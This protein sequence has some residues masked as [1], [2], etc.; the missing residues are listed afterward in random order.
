MVRVNNQKTIRSLSFHFIKVNRSRNIITIIAIMLTSVLFTSVFAASFSVIKSTMESEIRKSM[1]R[2]HICIENMTKEQYEMVKGD[3][4]F[5]KQGLSVFLALA[6]NEELRKLQTE[7]RY[8]DVN[9]AYSYICTPTTGSMPEKENEIATSTLVLDAFH[10]PHQVGQHIQLEFTMNQKIFIKDFIVTGFWEGDS[11]AM[12]QMVWVSQEYCNKVVT[13]ATQKD[14][15]DGNYAGGYDLSV[16]LSN[17]YNLEQEAEQLSNKYDL[18]NSNVKISANPAY[19]IFGVDG[20]PVA[21]IALILLVI[22]LAGYLII[23]NVF[24]ISVNMDIRAYGLLKN[25]GTTGKQLKTIV[26]QQAL[27]LSL[28]GIPLGMLAG[29]LI[30]ARMTPFLLSKEG[31]NYSLTA[32]SVNPW[33]FL[34]SALF[35]LITIYMGCLKPCRIVERLSPIEAIRMTD[36][37]EDGRGS[38]RTGSVK[39]LSMALSNCRR[40]WKKGIGVVISLILSLLLLNTVY[41]IVNGFD[42]N[43]YTETKISS[44]FE[45]SGFDNDLCYSNLNSINPQFRNEIEKNPNITT[46]GYVYYQ[47]GSHIVDDVLYSNIKLMIDARGINTFPDLVQKYINN[48]LTNRTVDCQIVGINKAIFDKLIFDNEKCSWEEFSKGEYVITNNLMEGE[49]YGVGD[50]VTVD[51]DKNNQKQYQ[52]LAKANL[53]YT[54]QYRFYTPPICPV[55]LIPDTE[56]VK[57]TGNEYAMIATLDVKKGTSRMVH[58]W[59]KKYES[60]QEIEYT[61]NVRYEIQKEFQAYVSKYYLIGGM[62]TVVLFIIGILNFLN[63]SITSILVRKRELSLLEVIGMTKRDMVKMLIVEGGCYA[64]LAFIFSVLMNILVGPI[65]IKALIGRIYFFSYHFTIM[66]CLVAFPLLLIIIIMIPVVYYRHICRE[67]LVERIRKEV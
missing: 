32:I 1:T 17:T 3:S 19:T 51:F 52:C 24:Q 30:G 42:F 22:M 65:V 18:V 56:F 37:E 53:P 39:P 29:F 34:A 7:V 61:V 12:A 11:I 14:L 67:T 27:Y 5:Q 4:K 47:Q 6:E 15:A 55:F 41:I 20:F 66:P 31:C 23:Y 48:T 63:T 59:I 33:I 10:L 45:I 8:G 58:D 28:I 13:Q 50:M 54:L 21:S 57:N 38:K 44:D 9:E 26:H 60:K 25:I 16:W 46:A 2:S 35:S 36:A 62:L 49:F 40:R 43:T 64:I